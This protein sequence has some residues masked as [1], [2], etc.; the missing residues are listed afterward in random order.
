MKN[1]MKSVKAILLYEATALLIDKV[2]YEIRF[3]IKKLF[4]IEI[5]LKILKIL[6]MLKK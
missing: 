1:Q 2:G 3:N 5:I 6:K 4:N